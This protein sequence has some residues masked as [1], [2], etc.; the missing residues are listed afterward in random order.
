MS[1]H[2]ETPLGDLAPVGKHLLSD[3][4][5]R[6]VKVVLTGEGSDEMFLGYSV[7][8]EVAERGTPSSLFLPAQSL[9]VVKF[10]LVVHVM[11][12]CYKIWRRSRR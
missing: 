1:R 4:A 3:L 6:H 8:R 9:N 5:Q 10:P 7:F 11:P 2:V 12:G